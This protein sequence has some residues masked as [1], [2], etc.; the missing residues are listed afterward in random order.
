MNLIHC[1]LGSEFHITFGTIYP[2]VVRIVMLDKDYISILQGPP[3]RTNLIPLTLRSKLVM[4]VGT[5]ETMF[6][7]VV[8]R[9]LQLRIVG[10]RGCKPRPGPS[11]PPTRNRDRTP[12]NEKF[13]VLPGHAN[14]VG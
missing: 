13:H 12:S 4:A 6:Y 2:A 9:V 5:F 8:L 11:H 10:H 1:L 14:T 3:K 7:V